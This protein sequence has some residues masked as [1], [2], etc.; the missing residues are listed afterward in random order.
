MRA[1]GLNACGQALAESWADVDAF[2]AAQPKG[3]PFKAVVKPGSPGANGD[4]RK[5]PVKLETGKTGWYKA[6]PGGNAACPV[7]CKSPHGKDAVCEFHH[8]DK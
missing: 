5:K 3:V 8:K 4:N 7:A 6:M 1:A 2:I